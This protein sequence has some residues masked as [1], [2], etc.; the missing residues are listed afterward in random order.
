MSDPKKTVATPGQRLGHMAL[1]VVIGASV[2]GYLIGVRDRPEVDRP[3]AAREDT[4]GRPAN[5][6]PEVVDY[7][8]MST[9]SRGPN[10]NWKQSLPTHQDDPTRFYGDESATDEE[11]AAA[12]AVRSER[13]AFS[14]APPVVPHAIDERNAQACMACHSG[15]F[16][17]GQVI[18][19]KMSHHY[20]PNCTQCHVESIQ[21]APWAVASAQVTES[22]FVG[23]A[24]PGRGERIGP[25]APPTIPH[26]VWMRSDC[27]TCHGSLGK[28]GLRTSHPWRVNCTQC[29]A[30][31]RGFDW[32]PLEVPE[33]APREESKPIGTLAGT[34]AP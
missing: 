25:G 15:G 4:A 12:V 3:E 28:E 26:A 32:S 23:M 22:Q 20:L 8:K 27:T 9:V 6:P 1:A 17:V 30:P 19:P 34:P 21:N 2:T 31:S 10:A 13:R 18:A 16:K 29:H 5:L 7:L 11:R 33:P 24:E 14:G